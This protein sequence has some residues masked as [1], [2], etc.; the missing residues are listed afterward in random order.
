[1][2]KNRRNFITK[3]RFSK[4][5]PGDKVKIRYMIFPGFVTTKPENQHIDVKFTEGP[6]EGRTINMDRQQI[7]KIY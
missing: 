2:S 7:E 6:W 1:M 5:K 4:L 3:A